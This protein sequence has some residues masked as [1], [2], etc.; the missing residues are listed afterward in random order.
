M[1]AIDQ[2]RTPS[3]PQPPGR[4]SIVVAGLVF[5]VAL[6]LLAWML[7]WF[8]ERQPVD[9]VRWSARA[10][11]VG[12]VAT[13]PLV[14][15]L[16]VL[17]RTRWGPF[18]DL[19]TLVDESIVP[20]FAQCSIADLAYL[21]IA[22]GFGEELLFRGVVQEV[23]AARYGPTVGLFVASLVFG[24]VHAVTR[25]YAAL[26]ALIG[27]YLG[28]LWLAT[29]NLLVPIVVHALYDFFALV[30]LSRYRLHRAK[31]APL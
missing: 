29:D 19:L 14:A 22:A 13:L 3:E 1:H 26:A 12:A 28:W 25:T 15:G 11:G 18:D 4:H 17:V 23:A 8:L 6:A 20:L 5:E 2:Q 27:I 31:D 24:L 9:Q 21:S 16:W 10:L 30:Y 7:G